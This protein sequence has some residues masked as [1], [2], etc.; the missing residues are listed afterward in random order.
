MRT[1]G[2]FA[3]VMAGLDVLEDARPVDLTRE[4]DHVNSG[5]LKLGEIGGGFLDGIPGAR[6]L[7]DLIAMSGSGAGGPV[8]P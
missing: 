7:M 2:T 4:G 8:R 3:A 5:V 6:P 1:S